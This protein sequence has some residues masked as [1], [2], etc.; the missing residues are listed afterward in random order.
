MNTGGRTWD[1]ITGIHCILILDE[2]E[3]IHQLHLGDLSSA[4]GRKVSLD[5]GF[6][7]CRKPVSGSHGDRESNGDGPCRGR[8]PKYSLVDD[9][10]VMATTYRARV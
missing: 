3:A 9:T 2:T 8:F 4:V 7:S 6:G 1:D 10:S 5:I